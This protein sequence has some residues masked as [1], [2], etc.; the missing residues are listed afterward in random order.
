[1]GVRTR[2]DVICHTSSPYVEPGPNTA[3]PWLLP[4]KMGLYAR[5]GTIKGSV[6]LFFILV[7]T[8]FRI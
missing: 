3:S 1:M 5:D 7:N 4:G 6:V 8:W 2:A